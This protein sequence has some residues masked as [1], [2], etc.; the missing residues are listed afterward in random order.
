MHYTREDGCRAWLPYG[1]FRAESLAV[2]LD[3]YGS[4][5][6]IYDK[7]RKDGSTFLQPYVNK[8]GISKL[9]EQAQRDKMH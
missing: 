4:A 2:L 1:M 3:E 7:F 8:Y 9:T 6:A 5:E